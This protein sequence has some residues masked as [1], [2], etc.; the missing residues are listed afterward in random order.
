[1]KNGD[2]NGY[3]QSWQLFHVGVEPIV[4]KVGDLIC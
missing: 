3:S 1:M 2:L 4:S